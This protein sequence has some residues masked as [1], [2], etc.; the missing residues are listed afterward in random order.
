MGSNV[1]S[2]V[3]DTKAGELEKASVTHTTDQISS[4]SDRTAGTARKTQK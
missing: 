1:K 2:F 4:R 3:E